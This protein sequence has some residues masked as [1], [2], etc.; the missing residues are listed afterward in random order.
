[1]VSLLYPKLFIL[2]TPLGNALLKGYDDKNE[3]LYE[4]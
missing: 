4:Y 3:R 1:M 2:I